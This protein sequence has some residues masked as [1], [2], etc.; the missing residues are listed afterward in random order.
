MLFMLTLDHYHPGFTI[1]CFGGRASCGVVIYGS[2]MSPVD[3]V[4]A[5][6]DWEHFVSGERALALHEGGMS[7]TV[8][9][10][11]HQTNDNF[12]LNLNEAKPWKTIR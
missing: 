7:I 2:P 3:Y 10:Q 12:M 1:K 5:Y 11:L 4:N 9:V 8:H 6:L